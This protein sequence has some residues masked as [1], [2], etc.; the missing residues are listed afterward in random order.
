MHARVWFV[1]LV[2]YFNVKTY[3]MEGNVTM[4]S[5]IKTKHIHSI[6]FRN[7]SGSDFTEGNITEVQLYKLRPLRVRVYVM[8]NTLGR[9]T[10]NT[11]NVV[12]WCR[13]ENKHLCGMKLT[14]TSTSS[15]DMLTGKRNGM[16]T[17]SQGHGIEHS[18]SFREQHRHT[19][20]YFP[21]ECSIKGFAINWYNFDIEDSL[22][23][24]R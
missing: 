22:N 18:F 7:I 23:I 5:D 17:K 9:T 4:R 11:T 24:D 3:D 13:S 20:L 16:V 15:Q 21:P 2:H 1:F 12:G 8:S 6:G 14:T 10:L 19:H